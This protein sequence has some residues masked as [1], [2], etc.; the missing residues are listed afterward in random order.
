M[1]GS[2]A[3]P[4][5]IE[6]PGGRVSHIIAKRLLAF[7]L[8]DEQSGEISRKAF[9]QPKVGPGRFSYR[10]AE[11]LVS[12][13][14]SHHTFYTHRNAEALAHFVVAPRFEERAGANNGAG[15]FHSAEPRRAHNQSK[16][17]VRIRT[18]RLAEECERR[19]GGRKTLRCVSGI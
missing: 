11:P 3:L 2:V 13:L 8:F 17:F 10:I 15:V 9:A 16:F 19:G 5:V 12:D 1:N 18:N 6:V 14:V 7:M 4:L